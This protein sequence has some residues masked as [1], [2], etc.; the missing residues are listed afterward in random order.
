MN[1]IKGKAL[2]SWIYLVLFLGVASSGCLMFAACILAVV[3]HKLALVGPLLLST[4]ACLVVAH[5]HLQRV[6]F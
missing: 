1:G 5:N 4:Y 2:D 6:K 3:E